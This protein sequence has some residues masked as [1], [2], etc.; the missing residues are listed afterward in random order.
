MIGIPGMH[1]SRK[2]MNE[3]HLDGPQGIDW[4]P[5]NIGLALGGIMRR[6]IALTI[7][8]LYFTRL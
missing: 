5:K 8:M 1:S 2:C 6:R 3:D 7:G 4:V